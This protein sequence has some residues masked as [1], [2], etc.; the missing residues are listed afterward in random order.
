[1][2]ETATATAIVDLAEP[3]F[4]PNLGQHG[5]YVAVTLLNL[6]VYGDT[7]SECF[8]KLVGANECAIDHA[9]YCPE[10]DPMGLACTFGP[11][12]RCN[13]LMRGQCDWSGYD[14]TGD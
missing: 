7:W 9:M 10:D 4:D 1:M 14:G 3:T 8:A 11:C 5:Q 6:E 13:P 12:A 2:E